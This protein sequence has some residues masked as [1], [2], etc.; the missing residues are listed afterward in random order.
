MI[1][2]VHLPRQ[3]HLAR[4]E[5]ASLIMR[6]LDFAIVKAGSNKPGSAPMIATTTS[7]LYEGET[8]NAACSNNMLDDRSHAEIL[9]IAWWR[10]FGSF[11]ICFRRIV[12]SIFFRPR[13]WPQ[14]VRSTDAPGKWKWLFAI[15][16]REQPLS[17][18]STTCSCRLPRAWQTSAKPLANEK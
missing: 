18:L 13:R 5:F 10:R 12:V 1:I 16:T 2:G 17:N 14:L 8:S 9:E 15:E 6:A 4:A 7:Q 11:A 3:H